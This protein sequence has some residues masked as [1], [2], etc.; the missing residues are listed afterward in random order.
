MCCCKCNHRCH[1][2]C[3]KVIGNIHEGC[4]SDKNIVGKYVIMNTEATT[5]RL[6]LDVRWKNRN[7]GMAEY[8]IADYAKWQTENEF[9]VITF[10]NSPY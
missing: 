8:K 3:I 5:G 10:K 9:K 7:K 2:C 4:C 1:C 6:V